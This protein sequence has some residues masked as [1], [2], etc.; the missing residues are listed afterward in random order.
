MNLAITGNANAESIST[1]TLIGG[2]VLARDDGPNTL[3]SYPSGFTV[4]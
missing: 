3:S 1:G 4:G 2:I